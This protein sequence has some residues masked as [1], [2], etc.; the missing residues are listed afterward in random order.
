LVGNR[1]RADLVPSNFSANNPED[2][3][4][5]PADHFG[6]RER[7]AAAENLWTVLDGGFHKRKEFLVQVVHGES[8]SVAVKS[9]TRSGI[10]KTFSTKP[11]PQF[12]K[13]NH[14]AHSIPIENFQ[15][16]VARKEERP[17]FR[18]RRSGRAVCR[19]YVGTTAC[20]DGLVVINQLVPLANRFHDLAQRDTRLVVGHD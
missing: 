14:L 4:G 1:S 2:F 9:S 3:I 20:G 13:E 6:S 8:S 17:R 12:F 15:A 16:F 19:L 5:R 18:Q 10:Q 7:C 11:K